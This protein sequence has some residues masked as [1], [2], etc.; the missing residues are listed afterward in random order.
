[1]VDELQTHIPD[2]NRPVQAQGREATN[3]TEIDMLRVFIR[4]NGR[5]RKTFFVL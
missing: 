2:H 5:I 3:A 1:M 4:I